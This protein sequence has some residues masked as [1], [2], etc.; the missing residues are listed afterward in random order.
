MYKLS[1]KS[2]DPASPDYQLGY[3]MMRE[4]FDELV[5]SGNVAGHAPAGTEC[6]IFDCERDSIKAAAEEVWRSNRDYKE[7][8]TLLMLEWVSGWDARP[9]G[10]TEKVEMTFE[11]LIQ[12]KLALQD[13]A[14]GFRAAARNFADEGKP[15]KLI[16]EMQ[17]A[18]AKADELCLKIAQHMNPRYF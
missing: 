2:T 7:P 18:A 10:K 9:E 15:I 16:K 14:S 8:D 1:I 5:F 6:V 17:D 4:I 3:M 13:Y 12:C 11:D